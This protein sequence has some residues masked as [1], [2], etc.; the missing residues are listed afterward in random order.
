MLRVIARERRHDEF[1]HVPLRRHH[2]R[3]RLASQRI[4]VEHH[5]AV[6]HFGDVVLVDI[7]REF[8]DRALRARRMR[9]D[10]HR[11]PVLVF[12]ERKRKPPDVFGT[13]REREVVAEGLVFECQSHAGVSLKV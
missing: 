5:R 4:G 12:D 11:I 10:V 9:L 8:E 3:Q 2:V 13:V 6:A 1:E 7:E